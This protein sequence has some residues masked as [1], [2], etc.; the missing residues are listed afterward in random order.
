M[1]RKQVREALRP[2]EP[3]CRDSGFDDRLLLQRLINDKDADAFAILYTKYHRRLV[4]YMATHT[5]VAAEAE[6]W[7]QDVFVQLWRTHARYEI[8]ESAEAY[9]FTVANQVIT[10]HMRQRKRQRHRTVM[11]PAVDSIAPNEVPADQHPTD[12]ISLVLAHGCPRNAGIRLSPKSSEAIR[13]RFVQA[14]SV[15]EAARMAGCSV[16]AFY[17]RLERALRALRQAEEQNPRGSK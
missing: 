12:W 17:S 14:L 2:E 16:A 3:S 1:A 10:W 15:P 9:L 5:G 11:D 13:L 6:D 8:G 4:C 7:T